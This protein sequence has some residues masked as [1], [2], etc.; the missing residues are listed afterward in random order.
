VN[1][2]IAAAFDRGGTVAAVVLILVV[3]I[4]YAVR[5]GTE[6]LIKLRD[7]R[8]VRD[9][10][11]RAA[12]VKDQATS[13]AQLLGLLDEERANRER[14]YQQ[15]QRTLAERDQKNA[16]LETENDVLRTKL[17]DQRSE[18]ERKVIDL[19]SRLR[20]ITD[21]LARFRRQVETKPR[22]AK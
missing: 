15:Y 20:A 17:I 1:E 2:I 10:K 9:G 13:Y 8:E 4:V 21:D 11:R 7:A 5:N 22:E 14:D 6:P 18:Y 3:A 19:E 12:L 16:A